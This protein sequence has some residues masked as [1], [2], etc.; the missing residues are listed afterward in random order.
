MRDPFLAVAVAIAMTISGACA[1]I[2]HACTSHGVGGGNITWQSAGSNGHVE[3]GLLSLETFLVPP[4]APTTCTAG[5]GLGSLASPAPAG[6]N[7]FEMAIVVVNAAT[8]RRRRVSAFSFVANATTTSSLAA[9]SGSSSPPNT[10]PL[11]SGSTW[12][13]FSSPVDPFP[14][15]T[16]GSGEF[17]AF[18]FG[19]EVPRSLLPLVLDAQFAGGEGGSDG[20]PIF[21]GDHPAQ[22]FTTADRSVTLTASITSPAPALSTGMTALATAVLTALGIRA[23]ARRAPSRHVR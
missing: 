12:F 13:G 10:N 5:I 19:V 8:G 14:P 7:V 15:P 3:M 4:T 11:F 1:R 22:Y 23:L 9:G 2:A 20:T 6:L 16:L 21:S 18:Q 17:I